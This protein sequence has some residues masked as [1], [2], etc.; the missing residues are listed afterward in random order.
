MHE[1]FKYA[2]ELMPT[3]FNNIYACYDLGVAC[4]QEI[5]RQDVYKVEPRNTTGRRKRNI[6][7]HKL[8]SLLEH[9]KKDKQ[10]NKLTINCNSQNSQIENNNVS[11]GQLYEQED[12]KRQCRVT[13]DNEKKILGDLLKYDNFSEDKAIKY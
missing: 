5:L 4:L 7:V 12:T 13:N 10:T 11:A 2:P 3:G 8:L 9:Q 6:V 1:I